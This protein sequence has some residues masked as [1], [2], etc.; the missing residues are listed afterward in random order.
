MSNEE[1]Q[2][3]PLIFDI[4]SDRFK[5][6]WAGDDSP[7]IIAPSVYVDVKDYIFDANV[8]DAISIY[9]VTRDNKNNPHKGKSGFKY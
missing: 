5:L 1:R 2:L 8:I 9:D 6:G 4:G 7:S 3:R